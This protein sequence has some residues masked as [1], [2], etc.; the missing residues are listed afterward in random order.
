[1]QRRHDGARRCPVRGETPLP[2]H[3]RLL[4][5][6]VAALCLTASA[7]AAEPRGAIAVIVHPER[8][9]S[10]ISSRAL[11]D[12]FLRRKQHWPDGKR[13][14]VLA[15]EARTPVRLAFDRAVLGM[16]ADDA[17]AYWIDR[18]IRGL[19]S[20]PRGLTSAALIRAIVARNRQ[21]IA[22]VPAEGLDRRVKVLRV[23]GRDPG[24]PG[25][26]IRLQRRHR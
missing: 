20:P 9:P 25:Y 6:A 1:M 11:A 4:L 21:A 16:S 7:A 8:K 12:I 14:V 5:G 2:R 23:D 10:S 22:Y 17:A 15:W 18:R 24:Q 26:P 13:V 19:G 3:A